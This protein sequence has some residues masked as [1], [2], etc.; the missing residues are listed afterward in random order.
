[1]EMSTVKELREIAKSRKIRGY[2]AMRKADLIAALQQRPKPII[3]R[4]PVDEDVFYDAISEAAPTPVVTPAAK[5]GWFSRITSAF[6]KQV[7]VLG[8]KALQSGYTKVA[9]WLSSNPPK[10]EI[11]EK[12]GKLGKTVDKLFTKVDTPITTIY[13]HNKL[14]N[15]FTVTQ[16]ALN[17]ITK[18]YSVKGI[19]G[20]DAD[21]FMKLVK[22]DAVKLLK[23]NL[24]S[25]VNLALTC[26]MERV[27]LKSGEVVTAEP[28]FAS[29]SEVV[30]EST[31]LSDFYDVATHKILETIS[32]FQQRGSNWRFKSVTKLDINTYVYKPLKGKS[33]IPL[34]D[35][36]T[37][38]KAIINLKNKDNE[39]FKWC[40]TRALNM[41]EDHPERITKDLRKQS[42]ELNWSGVEF[43]MTL[44]QITNFEKN[45][46]NVSV[47]VFG[48][49]KM[50]VYPLRV[51]EHSTR[52]HIVDLLLIAD[53]SKTHYCLINNLSRLLS[54]QSSSRD[55]ARL[56]CRRC[57]NDFDNVKSLTKH[58]MYCNNHDAVRPELPA[59]GTTLSFKNY[60][61]SMRVPFIVYADF[62]AFI[63]PIDTCQPN[64]SESYTK[65]Y[66]KHTPSSFCYKIK[67]FDDNIYKC[68]PV[69]FTAKREDDDV[70]Q[71]FFDSLKRH[72]KEI[73]NQFKFPKKM[74][75]FTDSDKKDFENATVC[76]ICEKEFVKEDIVVCDHCHFSGKYRGA[77][78]ESCN[79]NYKIPKFFP[80]V[81][82]NLSGYDSHLFIKKLAG[83]KINCI[84]NNE[85]KYISFSRE[86][87]VD[88]F[89]DKKTG[90]Q[91]QVKRELRFIDSFRFMGTSL[92]ALSKNL[93]KEQCKNI[94]S[95]Y[96]GKQLDLLLRKGVYPY[97][98]V[99]SLVKLDEPQL[100]PKEAFYSRLND[101]DISDDEYAHAQ[102]VWKEF[103]CKTFRDYHDLYNVSDVLLLTDVFENFRDVCMKNYRLD[104]AWSYTSPGLAWDAALKLTD[105]E[106]ELL[107][108]YDMILM[109]IHGIR[110]GISMI[111]NR[112]GEANNKYMGETYDPSKPSTYI[113]YLDANNLYGWAMSKSLPT[114]GFK[115]MSDDEIANWRLMPCILEVDMEYPKELHDLH[116]DYPL[117]PE[118]IT[119]NKV[120]KLVPNLNDKKNYVIHYENLKLYERLGL[121]ITNIHRG[122]RFEESDW[123]KRYIDLNTSLRTEATTE[124]E[125]DFFKLMNNSV[126]GK[127]MEN[128]ENR[129]DVRLVTTESE[130]I[131]LGAMPNYDRRT[132]FDE[133]LIAVHMKKT[134]LMYNKP[135][136][137]GMCIL[138]LSKTLMYDFHYNYVKNKYGD[139]AK[140][141]F[142]DTDSLAYEIKTDD[143]YADI[144]SDVESRFDTSDYPE[145]HPAIDGGFKVGINKKVIGMFKDEAGGK[146]IEEFVGLRSK[147]YSYKILNEKNGHKKC[148]GVKKNVVKKS[149]THRDYKNCLLTG[150]EHLRRMNVFRSHKHDIY[151]EEVNK[152]A[153][154]ADDDKRI[155]LDDLVSTY[156]HGHC[157][158]C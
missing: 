9:N 61:R 37:A 8:F 75:I 141:L 95:R 140:L 112:L 74:T 114:H 131:K 26:V 56:Y 150:R 3:I 152:V 87:V 28:T 59:P 53:S 94:A 20:Y 60:N 90:K 78:H 122:I 127:T 51:S 72:I 43:P 136:Y 106:L 139:R 91:V 52:E 49:E 142:T 13:H 45:N 84:P 47:N 86:I 46:D 135:I 116:N 11:V 148:K 36:L 70:A 63:K 12:L 85:E 25:K 27:D 73:Y 145:D 101:S 19:A 15:T 16:S 149:I 22:S 2:Y 111:S 62:E 83:G 32:T 96:S 42:E 23:D 76:H 133:N 10:Q 151:T 155:V 143:F 123:L 50:A 40:V 1:M 105:V 81:F 34:P 129:V 109:I 17:N 153:L 125:K 79:L 107:S 113:Q 89:I 92:D 130:A 29:K 108:D 119:L 48:Y 137:L 118:S 41:V 157:K 24:Q 102:T 55:R 126:F 120:N 134:K 44:N 65:Q 144:A 124:F 128:I 35:E 33:Y 6:T 4:P 7:V 77:A 117:A 64:P 110:G 121:K 88:E 21:S 99:D 154:S 138:D 146:Q 71:I 18:Q 38:K 58:Q 30:L 80:V 93:T 14:R 57:L 103:E 66:Q 82:H 5:S 54:S 147:L 31:D 68:D 98:W 158:L 132:I 69:T 39:C 67:C 156:A 104:P 100:P 115:W 97:E